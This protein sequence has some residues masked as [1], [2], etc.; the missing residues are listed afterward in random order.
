MI[1]LELF[2][3]F[4]KIGLFSFGGGLA[5]IPFLNALA[6]ARPTWLTREAIIDML[7]VSESTPGPIGVNIAT[8]VGF[9][10]YGI[11]GGLAATLGLITPSIICILLIVRIL[12]RFRDS[13][14]VQNVFVGIRPAAVGLI[15]CA[16]VEVLRECFINLSAWEARA[17]TQLFDWWGL[18]FFGALLFLSNKIKAHPVLFIAIGGV[19]GMI[20]GLF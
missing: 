7:A 19:V 12:D 3:E 10:L 18:L 16:A 6:D 9:D 11:C 20:K 13:N 8:Y 17:F 5:T 1:C 2:F 14:V 15:G 4:F